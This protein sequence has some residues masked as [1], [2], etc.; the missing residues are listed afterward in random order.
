MVNTGGLKQVEGGGGL[1]GALNWP[2][3]IWAGCE[4]M[5]CIDKVAVDGWSQYARN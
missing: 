3:V 5:K 1:F 4:V 2:S